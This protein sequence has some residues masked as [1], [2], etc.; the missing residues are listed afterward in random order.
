MQVRHVPS[1]GERRV[2]A[3]ALERFENTKRVSE[4]LCDRG[5]VARGPR[6]TVQ[7]EHGRRSGPSVFAHKQ[8]SVKAQS[9]APFEASVCVRKRSIRA[10]DPGT[11]PAAKKL[12]GRLFG[13]A[14]CPGGRL[15]DS[16]GG[17]LCGHR[18]SLRGR[19]RRLR[20]LLTAR[21]LA[22]FDN[23][24]A[25]IAAGDCA[26]DGMMAGIVAGDCAS[27]R[28]REASLGIGG[29]GRG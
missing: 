5:H 27:G 29:H 18:S 6:A 8:H 24:V 7:N 12:A 1:N 19:R 13:S 28:A 3:P 20:C 21:L 4:V 17:A 26:D 11:I 2:G 15:A 9:S 14:L 25:G 22:A 16:F 10:G 23:V